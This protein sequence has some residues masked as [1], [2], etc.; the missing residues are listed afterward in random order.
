MNNHQQGVAPEDFAAAPSL[1]GRFKVLSTNVDRGGR[2]FVSSLE[3]DSLPIYATQYHPEKPQVGRG[4]RPTRWFRTCDS[5]SFRP[6]PVPGLPQFE[7]DPTEVIP[8]FYDAVHA[9]LWP[10]LVFVNQTR[11]NSEG[12]EP[13]GDPRGLVSQSCS[14]STG[15]ASPH[16]QTVPS[17]RPRP[18]PP[19]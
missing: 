18:R 13:W 16:R 8:H 9:N 19:P 11:L 3:G 1:A 12:C 17:Q 15:N 7:W 2:P 4:A 14:E 5:S 6:R 10:G